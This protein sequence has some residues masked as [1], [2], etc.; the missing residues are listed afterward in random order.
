MLIGI[1]GTS[2]AIPSAS[3]LGSLTDTSLNPR[4]ALG[5]SPPVEMPNDI[6]DRC[7][8]CSTKGGARR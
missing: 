5:I 3:A 2:I 4:P 1:G 7:T 8:C 6:A